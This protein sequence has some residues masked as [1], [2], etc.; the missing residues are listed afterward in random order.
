MVSD[1]WIDKHTIIIHFEQQIMLSQQLHKSCSR[2]VVML[3]LSSLTFTIIWRMTSSLVNEILWRHTL[4]TCLQT[5]RILVKSCLQIAGSLHSILERS[6]LERLGKREGG[7][8]GS[9]TAMCNYC[10]SC[11]IVTIFDRLWHRWIW[12]QKLAK[13]RA[14]QSK[15][16]WLQ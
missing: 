2:W 3:Y 11:C 8:T 13:S 7:D 12:P 10:G 9:S 6:L 1:L 5:Y 15:G 14:S 4:V 16:P